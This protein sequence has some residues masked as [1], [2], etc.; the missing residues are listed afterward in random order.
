MG[1]SSGAFFRVEYI[2]FLVEIDV[3]SDG[4]EFGRRPHNRWAW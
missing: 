3:V 4:E 2:I 1:D